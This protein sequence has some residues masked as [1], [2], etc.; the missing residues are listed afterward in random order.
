MAVRRLA[1]HR[2]ATG[3]PHRRRRRRRSGALRHPL[4]LWPA[5]GNAAGDLGHLADPAAGGA[6]DLRRQQPR[7]RYAVVDVG[8]DGSRRA[9]DHLQPAFDHHL[10][11]GGV[12]RAH[13]GAEEHEVRALHPR[14][15]AEP[16]HGEFHGHPHA[17]GRRH[18]LRPRFRHRRHRGRRTVADRQRLAQSRPELHHRQFHG[19]RVRRRRKPLGH[20]GWRDDARR[21]QQVPGTLCRRGAGQDPAARLHHPVHPEAPARPVRLKGRAVEA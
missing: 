7:G 2:A 14:R 17:L 4:P 19:R 15:H 5:A 10:F 1:R 11:A 20:A 9:D 21:R 6:L 12:R 16:A 13:H 18:D 3:L 8:A